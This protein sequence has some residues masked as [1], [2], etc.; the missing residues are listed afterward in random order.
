MK[1]IPNTHIEVTLRNPLNKKD[2]WTYQI[3]PLDIPLAHAWIDKLKLL[4]D[5]NVPI[6]KNYCFFGFVNS[7]RN[8]EYI[9]NELNNVVNHLNKN[10][11]NYHIPEVFNEEA[12]ILD[13]QYKIN[14]D[15]MN[16]LHLHF[17]TLQGTV[18]K[19]SDYYNKADMETRYCIRQ[20]NNLCH[21]LES[22]ILSKRKFVKAPKWSQTHQITTLLNAPR[23]PL[24]DEFYD[25]FLTNGYDREYGGVYMHWAQIG[26][27][28]K[29][30]F[31]D[32]DGKPVDD[33]ICS[34]ITPLRYYSGEF[35]VTFARDT[36][37]TPEHEEDMQVYY[38]WLEDNGFDRKDKKLS[39]GYLKIGQVN[40]GSIQPESM[41]EN[42]S[43][44]L[45]IYKIAIFE[46]YVSVAENVFDYCWSDTDFKQKQ[47]EKLAT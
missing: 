39:L 35:D 45:D 47:I 33:V 22:Y 38:Q 29:E 7:P 23:Y 4:L 12:V 34:A 11:E 16:R 1:Y 27:T 31:D 3:M 19:M 36:K 9:C 32:E 13:D 17:E 2:R 24:E 40:T 46:D 41:W 6:E 43:G 14:H 21:E 20:L 15:I 30:V 37:E 25:G 42:I 5:S 28:H 10:I 26:K 8:I 44:H 18:G